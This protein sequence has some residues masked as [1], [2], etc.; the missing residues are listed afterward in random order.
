MSLADDVTDLLPRLG[1]E[2]TAADVIAL[3][4]DARGRQVAAALTALVRAGAVEAVERADGDTS[5][6]RWRVPGVLAEHVSPGSNGGPGCSDPVGNGPEAILSDSGGGSS[7]PDA[8]AVEATN[9]PIEPVVVDQTFDVE[10]VGGCDEQCDPANGVHHLVAEP[11]RT[12]KRPPRAT[13]MA[14]AARR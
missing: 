14:R 1:S 3:G 6:R 4:L 13:S 5:P 9:P 11:V 8:S 2:F 10:H 12:P 7:A